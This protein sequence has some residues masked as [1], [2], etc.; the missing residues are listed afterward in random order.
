MLAPHDLPATS[1]RVAPM[2][3]LGEASLSSSR[4]AAALRNYAEIRGELGGR[5]APN[6]AFEALRAGKHLLVALAAEAQFADLESVVNDLEEVAVRH[7]E[8]RIGVAWTMAVRMVLAKLSRAGRMELLARSE[9]L[10][11]RFGPE[12]AG[13]V[14]RNYGESMAI[15]AYREF[16]ALGEELARVRAFAG[17]DR[18]RR[19][20]YAALAA[21]LATLVSD[22]RPGEPQT[23]A[24]VRAIVDELAQ[25]DGASEALARA[26]NGL[27]EVAAAEQARRRQERIELRERDPTAAA[28]EATLVE[29]GFATPTAIDEAAL[30]GRPAWFP[31]ERRGWLLQFDAETGF[32]PHREH[33]ALLTAIAGR[34]GRTISIDEDCFVEGR[35]WRLVFTAGEQHTLES[36]LAEVDDWVDVALLFRAVALVAGVAP[37]YVLGT[38][39]QTVTLLIAPPAAVSALEAGGWFKQRGLKAKRLGAAKRKR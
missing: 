11:E 28:L 1:R 26:R 12:F 17:A 10:A 35:G 27:P 38:G 7:P 31:F 20:V 15:T 37:L 16:D 3:A 34:L 6:L 24:W 9:R 13:A 23:V 30:D 18:G 4:I 8:P 33:G 22:M 25:I 29:A 32:A 2:L 36:P 14:I 21:D 39:D 19:V 5:S